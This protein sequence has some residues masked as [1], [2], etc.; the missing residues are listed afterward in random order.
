MKIPKKGPFFTLCD[1]YWCFLIR[2]V[3]SADTGESVNDI[4]DTIVA[5]HLLV[6][7]AI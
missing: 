6:E 2:Y 4:S 1:L 3:L 7:T 5:S